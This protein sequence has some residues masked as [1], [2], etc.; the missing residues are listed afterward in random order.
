M[1]VLTGTELTGPMEIVTMINIIATYP[2]WR[3]MSQKRTSS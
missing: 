2:T 3:I 1:K